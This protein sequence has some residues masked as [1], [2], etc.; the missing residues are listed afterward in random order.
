[1]EHLRKELADAQKYQH[2]LKEIKQ[3]KAQL[4]DHLRER[5]RELRVKSAENARDQENQP[6]RPHSPYPSRPQVQN[7]ARQR[8]LATP[9]AKKTATREPAERTPFGD[10]TNYEAEVAEQKIEDL[11]SDHNMLTPSPASPQKKTPKHVP[12]IPLSPNSES[13]DTIDELA[14]CVDL[15]DQNTG[16]VSATSSQIE[17][18]SS[19]GNIGR[20]NM[21]DGVKVRSI[22]RRRS[23]KTPKSERR[24]P[25]NR[26]DFCEELATTK[27]PPKWYLDLLVEK[28]QETEVED[29]APQRLFSRPRPGTPCRPLRETPTSGSSGTRWR[30]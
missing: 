19:G 26:I 28:N 23:S 6:S 17:Q 14:S 16:P 30:S 7:P 15:K 27:S 22:L 8:R 11:K 3:E 9:T 5:D 1:M 21:Y 18:S 2:E 25:G 4:Q 24:K 29:R 10:L 12:V 13:C 20:Y